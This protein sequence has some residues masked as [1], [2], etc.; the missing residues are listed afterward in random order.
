MKTQPVF[1]ILSVLVLVCVTFAFTNPVSANSIE[2]EEIVIDRIDLY[3]PGLAMDPCGFAVQAHLYGVERLRYFLNQDGQYIHIIDIVGN[4][5]VDL[6]SNGKTVNVQGHG[7]V[8]FDDAYYADKFVLTVKGVGTTNLVTIPK[9]GV[10]MGGG[11]QIVREITFTADG[12]T[13]QILKWVGNLN[14]D[15]GPLCNY[16]AS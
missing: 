2:K 9:E 8:L 15:W 11:G 5:H 6:T 3:G 1:R 12:K 16:F 4:V 13:I 10:I 7:P 14:L